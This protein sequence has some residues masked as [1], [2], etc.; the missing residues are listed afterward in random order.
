MPISESA[1]SRSAGEGAATAGD[2]QGTA[3]ARDDA[4]EAVRDVNTAATA[5]PGSLATTLSMTTPGMISVL[6][7]S[8]MAKSLVC[9]NLVRRRGM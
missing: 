2:I 4:M 8:Q 5:T 7:E 1:T 3:A 9:M 6:A